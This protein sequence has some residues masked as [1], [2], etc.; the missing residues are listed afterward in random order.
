[1]ET[2]KNRKIAYF[3]FDGTLIHQDS[4][5][6]YLK[7]ALPHYRVYGSLLVGLLKALITWP[8]RKRS[9]RT[10]IKEA[11][12]KPLKNMPIDRLEQ[13]H[14]QLR[15][16]VQ[17]LLS[18]RQKLLEL[19]EEGYEIVI[20]SGALDIYLEALFDDLPIDRFYC[21]QMEINNGKLTGI[22]LSKNCVRQEKAKIIESE[23]SNSE[24]L[25]AFGDSR[26]DIY[27]FESVHEA[28]W[29]KGEII[30][31]YKKIDF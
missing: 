27:M 14:P 21:T 20:I 19:K 30:T 26:S 31:P 5:W 15:L 28:Y 9:Y 1:M 12:L 6:L 4:L 11:L 18:A 25:V 16:Q 23:R 10:V 29:V 8:F 7:I 13:H 22:M 2:S 17:P 24:H 3:D